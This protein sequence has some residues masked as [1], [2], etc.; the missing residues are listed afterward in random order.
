[1]LLLFCIISSI[2]SMC[3]LIIIAHVH[4]LRS[5]RPYLVF[6]SSSSLVFLVENKI[7]RLCNRWPYSRV[8][9]MR[10]HSLPPP[11]LW[12]LSTA[13]M[14]CRRMPDGRCR[15][16]L[17]STR[18]VTRFFDCVCLHRRYRGVRTARVH[19]TSFPVAQ[20][21][22]KYPHRVSNE[23]NTMVTDCESKN[24]CNKCE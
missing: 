15:D 13:V 21:P 16:H 23:N 20:I 18:T 1:M 8:W 2:E 4:N 10:H 7:L 5:P 12:Q 24:S 19:V 22:Q 17:H 9:Q 6:T 3:V 11:L 14:G